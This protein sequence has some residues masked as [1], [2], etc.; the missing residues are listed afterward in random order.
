MSMLSFITISGLDYFNSVIGLGA[1]NG[2]LL[3]SLSISVIIHVYCFVRYS[4]SVCNY[5]YSYFMQIK[6]QAL[7]IS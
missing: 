1:M 6:I 2:L 5:F 3:V 7:H 4:K